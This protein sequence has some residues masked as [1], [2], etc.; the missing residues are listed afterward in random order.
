MLGAGSGTYLCQEIL[1][2]SESCRRRLRRT[3]PYGPPGLA[4]KASPAYCRLYLNSS[5]ACRSTWQLSSA[6]SPPVQSEFHGRAAK[7]VLHTPADILYFVQYSGVSSSIPYKKFE[8]NN[9]TEKKECFDH[10]LT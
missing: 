4:I 10:S 9:R 2:R 7:Q 6:P 3:A 8:K 5:I 1:Y